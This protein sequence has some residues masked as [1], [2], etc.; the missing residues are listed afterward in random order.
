MACRLRPLFLRTM[1]KKN[2]K[3]ICVSTLQNGYTLSFDG[4]NEKSGYMYFSIEDLLKG[5]MMHIGLNMTDQLD[6]DSVDAFLKAVIQWNDNKKCVAEIRR[7]T[8][9]LNALKSWCNTLGKKLIKE[10]QRLIDLTY[11]IDS[12]ASEKKTDVILADRLREY[13]KEY[14]PLKPYTRKELHMTDR[15]SDEHEAE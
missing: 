10:R 2:I 6:M 12:I 15:S 11:L 4:M 7:L 14:T 3:H 5:F 9:Q 13:I 8:T 1:K